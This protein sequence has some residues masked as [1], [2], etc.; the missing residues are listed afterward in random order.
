[1]SEEIKDDG[2]KMTD[3]SEE[4]SMVDS[5]QSIEEPLTTYNLQPTTQMEV[6]H[7]PHVEKKSFKEYLLEGLM[8]FL[9]VSMG[10]IAENIR[11]HIVEKRQVKEYMIQ[12]VENLK[13]DT[14]RMNRN[15]TLNLKY[16]DYI[17]SFRHEILEAKKGNI[18]TYKLY[19]YSR[20]YSWT[21]VAFNTSAITQLK[22]SGALRLIENKKLVENLDDYYQ[23][24]ISSVNLQKIDEEE[25]NTRNQLLSE[26]FSLE[27]FEEDLKDR[28]VWDG[29]GV[30]SNRISL[31]SS[32]HY[33]IYKTQPED[34]RKLY[35][36]IYQY[37]FHLTRYIKFT[38][39]TKQMA[40]ELITDI[41]KEY[42]LENE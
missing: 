38:L 40:E 32:I 16:C 37:E 24:R 34:F 39:W 20:S 41:E 23:R 1:M 35:N 21:S 28:G 42:H 15:N 31:D 25:N 12:L 11:E 27:Y 26:F 33:Q 29:K 2:L 17:D 3:D 5:Q 14:T 6:H 30:F 22:N 19:H 13:Y 18:N 10:F 7:H 4:Q 8:I 36:S 9:A